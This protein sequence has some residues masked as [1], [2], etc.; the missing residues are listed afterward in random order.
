[1]DFL[2]SVHGLTN[3]AKSRDAIASKNFTYNISTSRD[4]KHPFG[5]WF[6]VHFI[7]K[8]ITSREYFGK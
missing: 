3:L 4:S 5:G 7:V 1:M 6:P 2:T 8:L